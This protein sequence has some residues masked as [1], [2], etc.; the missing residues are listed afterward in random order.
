[1][2]PCTYTPCR[3]PC[4][5]FSLSILFLFTLLFPFPFS[6]HSSSQSR[7]PYPSPFIR[8]ISSSLCLSPISFC[9]DLTHCCC[10]SQFLHLLPP[11]RPL[12]SSRPNMTIPL[13][14][15]TSRAPGTCRAQ[16]RYARDHVT[17]TSDHFLG[18]SLTSFRFCLATSTCLPSGQGGHALFPHPPC[19][20]S[21]FFPIAHTNPVL[22]TL[23]YLRDGETMLAR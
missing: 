19:S 6:I 14:C 3:G 22:P 15:P 16:F 18:A 13:S 2:S 11:P 1:M 5:S 7:S 4:T 8:T 10:P 12:P 20:S 23:P 9:L 17:V 21:S